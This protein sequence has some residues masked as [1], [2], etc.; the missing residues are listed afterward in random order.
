MERGKG[1]SPFWRR[2]VTGG[3]DWTRK[4]YKMPS[5]RAPRQAFVVPPLFVRQR[6]RAAG[7]APA[8]PDDLITTA[9]CIPKPF[10]YYGF[11]G[12]TPNC[13]TGAP[14]EETAMPTIP[15]FQPP[16]RRELDDILACSHDPGSS[17][18]YT[19]TDWAIEIIAIE[20]WFDAQD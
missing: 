2:L 20:A 8:R 14:T 4:A 7:G 19:L 9:Y 18:A 12:L 17:M 15:F 16:T 1:L 13:P 5:A 6:D 3:T 10:V 11:Q